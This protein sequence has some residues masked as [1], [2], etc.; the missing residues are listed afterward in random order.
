MMRE[1][2]IYT[3]FTKA[4]TVCLVNTASIEFTVNVHVAESLLKNVNPPPSNLNLL[5]LNK[6]V[7]MYLKH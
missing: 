7:D 6:I 3:M 2:I 5:L 1:A 4:Q